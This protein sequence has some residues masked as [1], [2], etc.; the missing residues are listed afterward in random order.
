MTDK[1]VVPHA[2]D[3]EDDIFKKHVNRRHVGRDG[4]L[5]AYGDNDKSEEVIDVG[6]AV[7]D[8][9]HRRYPESFDHEHLEEA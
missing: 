2:N 1:A 8:Y 9:W 6:R 5:A 4:F 3:M 7:H